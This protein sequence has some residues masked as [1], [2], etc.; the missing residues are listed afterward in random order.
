MK[1]LAS[2]A[3]GLETTEGCVCV[4]LLWL[5]PY[6]GKEIKWCH[7]RIKSMTGRYDDRVDDGLE[8]SAE[9]SWTKPVDA[10]E[11]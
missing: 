2:Y 11:E 4:F 1:K 10:A 7:G 3:D 6:Q 5:V 8:P 9:W